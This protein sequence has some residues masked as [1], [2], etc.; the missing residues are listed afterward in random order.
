MLLIWHRFFSD[1]VR[2]IL[3]GERILTFGRRN[4][5]E[6]KLEETKV[7]VCSSTVCKCWI[8][9]NFKSSAEPLCPI[10]NSKMILTTKEL[11]VINNHSQKTY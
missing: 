8:R 2:L 1:C 9:D 4:T 7:W 11:Q 10:C 3:K 5:E 6:I